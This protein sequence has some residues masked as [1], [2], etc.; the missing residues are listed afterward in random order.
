MTPN[1]DSEKNSSIYIDASLINK[2][3]KIARLHDHLN[4]STSL[5]SAD[6]SLI[7]DDVSVLSSSPSSSSSIASSQR[8]PPP[9]FKISNKI[10]LKQKYAETF[11]QTKLAN[12]LPTLNENS[13]FDDVKV[14]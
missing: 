13:P 8:L 3:K 11:G 10:R 4:I 9:P 2:N 12:P 7:A 6:S 1:E 14:N 5:T